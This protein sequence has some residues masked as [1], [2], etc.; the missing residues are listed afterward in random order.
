MS[1]EKNCSS[2]Y[3]NFIGNK[4]VNSIKRL[5]IIKNN[6]INQFKYKIKENFYGTEVPEA[7]L[8]K[9]HFMGL[10]SFKGLYLGIKRILRCNPFHKGGYDPVPKKI[11]RN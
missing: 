6:L 5:H 9:G 10:T 3:Y 2:S 4:L 7:N 11:E 8:I 1:N